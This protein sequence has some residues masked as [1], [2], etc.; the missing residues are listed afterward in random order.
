MDKTIFQKYFWLFQYSI[1]DEIVWTAECKLPLEVNFFP[2]RDAGT[3]LGTQGQK[4]QKAKGYFFL[5]FNNI[6]STDVRK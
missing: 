6:T 2:Y 4:I 1:A 5:K 3:D